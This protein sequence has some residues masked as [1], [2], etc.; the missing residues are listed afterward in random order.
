V[1][2]ARKAMKRLYAL[3]HIAPGERAQRILFDERPPA[4]SRIQGLKELARL[5]S[6]EQQA[7]AIV[8][9]KIPFR[10]AVSVIKQVTPKTL[11]AL[12]ERMSPQEL[13]NNLAMLRRYG[14][15]G[16]PDL[17]TMI[18]L[19]L[20]EAKVHKRISTFKAETAMAAGDVS[21]DVRKKLEEVADARIKAKGRIRR[22][23]ALFVDKSG[24]MDEAIE[25][26]KRIAAMISVACEKE[27]YVYAFDAFAFPVQANGTDWASWQRAFAGVKSHGQTACGAPLE[28]MIRKKQYA[29]QIIMVTD[30]EELEPPF[31]VDSFMKYRQAMSVDPGICIV[32]VP[33]SSTRLQDQCKRAGI[34]VATF[35]FNGDYYSLPNLVPLLEPPSEM[36]LIMEIM[37]Y[38]L[39]ER[40]SR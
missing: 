2:T 29:E 12:I 31:F 21:D 25:L 15:F 19:K 22:P 38:P 27:L 20:D 8:E 7:Q 9:S 17:K 18:D 24:S 33:D 26:G 16:N 34:P 30:E 23:T 28:Y 11:E 4:D 14:A 39:P 36:D 13:V 37:D 10:I 35:D 32:R 3:L 5:D 6:P 1:L 40:Q